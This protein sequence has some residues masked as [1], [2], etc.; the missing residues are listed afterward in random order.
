MAA[1]VLAMVVANSPLSHWYDMLLDV[2]VEARIGA[3]EIAKPLIL[4]INDGL[5]AVFFFMVGLELKREVMAGEL[6]DPSSVILPLVGAAGGIIVP[7]G[8]YAWFNTGDAEAMAGWAIPAATDIAFALGVLA[9]F[10]SR[11]PIALKV[12][13]VSI[14]IFDDIAAIVIIAVFYSGNLSLTALGVA[15]ACIVVLFAMNRRGVSSN[16][17][18]FWVGLI[19][20]TALLKSGVHATLAGVALAAFIPMQARDEPDRSPLRELESDLHHL[21]AF[22]I[23][24]IFAFANAGIPFARMGLDD[25]FHPV[26]AGIILGLFVGKQLGV[27]SFC[28]LAIRLG[29]ARMPGGMTYGMLYGGSALCGIG[30]TMSMF[31]GSLAFESGSTSVDMYFDER[32]GIVVGSLLSALLAALILHLTL[33]KPG[34]PLRPAGAAGQGSEQ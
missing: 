15:L 23:L 1:A 32:L 29:L 8:I 16:A 25:L 17:S 24:P 7:V 6:S 34:Q 9:L 28:S 4:W 26:S 33:P 31:I 2:P 13:L 12:F 19:M 30:F 21:V 20:W 18:Y 3:L 22:A 14:A 27:A 11:V 10:G 5:M